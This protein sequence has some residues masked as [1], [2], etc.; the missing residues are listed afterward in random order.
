MLACEATEYLTS[1]RLFVSPGQQALLRPK[2]TFQAWCDSTQ[3]QTLSLGC[4]CHFTFKKS[5]HI[6]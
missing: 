5:R 3:Q 6:R 1:Y 2:T 4:T